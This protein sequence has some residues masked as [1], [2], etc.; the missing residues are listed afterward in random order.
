[1]ADGRPLDELRAEAIEAARGLLDSEEALREALRAIRLDSERSAGAYR[2]VVRSLAI[3]LAARDGYTSDHS[4]FVHQ[5]A[6]AVCRRLGLDDHQ[7]AEVEAAALLHDIG[8]IGV[9]DHVLNKRGPLDE[10]EWIVMRD[11]PVI[12]E[13]IL[14]PLP[15]LAAVATAIR[16][17]HERWDGT[18]YPDGLAGEAIPLAS[19]VVLACDAYNALVSDRPYRS[20]L[21]VAEA[22][23]ELRRYAG[24][25][26][27]P[28]VVA[29]LEASLD[30]DGS[31]IEPVGVP[32]ASAGSGPLD[33][34][35][36]DV[37]RLENE[38]HALVTVASAVATVETL[39]DLVEVAA[40]EAWH[41]VAATSV[42]ISRF[43]AGGRLMRVLVNVG[44]LA[45]WEVR[46]PADETYRIDDDD[47]LRGLLLAGRSYVTSLDDPEGLAAEHVLLRAL[48]RH[49]SAAVP[50]VLGG[51]TWG[52]L[53]A[54]RDA[55]SPMFTE[56]DVRVL[57]AI[58]GQ[59]AAAVGRTELFARM[60][61]LAFRDALTG[62]GNRRALEER[63]ELMVAEAL[64]SGGELAVLLCDVDN[65]KEL[66]DHR[67]HT[68]GDEA[69]RQMA[70]TL[71]AEA[72]GPELVY[73]IGGDEFCLLLP[74][75]DW[76]EAKAL[77]ER[78]LRLLAE[79]ASGE[80]MASCG[81]ASLGIGLERA[82]D[83]LRAADTAQYAAKRG[84]RGRVYAADLSSTETWAPP[85]VTHR[86]RAN[87]DAGADEV[88]LRVLRDTLGVLDG[89][90]ALAD[91]PARPE[92]LVV[93][94]VST[95]DASRGAVSRY[96]ES[97]GLL[98]EVFVFDARR[99]RIW[100][101]EFA[102][103]L[104]D[105][106]RADDYPL[107]VAIL[108]GGAFVVERDD[109]SADPAELAALHELGMAA[110]LAAAAE[111]A[112]GPWLVELYADDE[113]SVRALSAAMDAVRLLVGEAAR[114]RRPPRRTSAAA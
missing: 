104:G 60:A 103:Q 92:D 44:T 28:A 111:G 45:D 7:T 29:A 58:A 20:A 43:E 61:D 15:E 88:A 52:E 102:Q 81:V 12:G 23:A 34:T 35:A 42:A 17:A 63:I 73:R 46:R 11:H 13:R 89:A 30:D 2:A 68:A 107:T 84:G 101:R 85:L 97:S 95:L 26:F 14:R 106:W 67:G 37:R 33:A 5:L 3:A 75:L 109:P 57:E 98:E 53:W 90:L 87:R 70:D 69:L 100:R 91:A 40:E 41:A 10:S 4:T 56:R 78:V 54:C 32:I 36:V 99:E 27:D 71:A 77:G 86:R 38:V 18:G 16:H 76:L 59:V 6:S 51:Q 19:R 108:D 83:L 80:L 62:V 31:L 1:M 47:E 9:P 114:E 105:R 112:G 65:L 72:P 113:A 21:G 82:T 93:R 96:V 22:K 64:E 110:V 25:Q 55:D 49:S 79:R 24:T 8:K 50:I 39:D 66:N 48:G 74:G 94:L